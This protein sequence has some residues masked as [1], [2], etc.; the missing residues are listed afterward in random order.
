MTTTVLLVLQPH[1]GLTAR[2]GASRLVGTVAGGVVA[3]LLAAVLRDRLLVA[4]AMFPLA[5]LAVM[6]R[7]VHYGLFT[8]FLTP[9]FVLLA[10]PAV[11]DWRLAAVRASDTLIGGLLAVVASRVLWPT[12]QHRAL[13]GV[14]AAMVRATRDY[15]RLVSVPGPTAESLARTRR[16]VGL[17]ATEAEAALDRLVAEPRGRWRD[18]EALLALVARTRRLNGAATALAAVPLPAGAGPAGPAPL[19]AAADALL[20]EVADALEAGRRPAPAGLTAAGELLGAA[21][22]A[23]AAHGAA[24]PRDEALRRLARHA[25]GVHA[26]AVRLLDEG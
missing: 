3:A 22:P 12:W 4:G 18:A 2:R 19:A 11:G 14:V 23:P 26:A 6:V 1:A 24:D 16:R 21:A 10:E 25:A 13:P 15:V 8:F 7:S 17:A 20:G 5:A 9:L